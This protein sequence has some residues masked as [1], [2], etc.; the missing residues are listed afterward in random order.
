MQV[1]DPPMLK[2]TAT[3]VFLTHHNTVGAAC[4][5]RVKNTVI[6][7][8]NVPL[9]LEGKATHTA[10]GCSWPILAAWWQHAVL[11]SGTL[12]SFSASTLFVGRQEG[13]PACES[14]ATTVPESLSSGTSVTCSNLTW[15][16]SGKMGWLNENRVFVR[17]CVSETVSL[18]SLS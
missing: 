14:F 9:K 6:V 5:L 1:L 18:R 17:V 8:Q 4:C 13:H 15:S 7:T 16:N 11:Q 2:T 12:S 10:M 3:T